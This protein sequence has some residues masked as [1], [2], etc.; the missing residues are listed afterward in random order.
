[1]SSISIS[2]GAP[3]QAPLGELTAL[4]EIPQMDLRGPRPT[5]KRKE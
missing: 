3:S 1:M 5:S 2:A 4:L